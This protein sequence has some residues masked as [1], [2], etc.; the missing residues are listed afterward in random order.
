M[1]TT[2][3]LRLWKI[4]RNGE[5]G[6]INAHNPSQTQDGR[7]AFP[8]MDRFMRACSQARMEVLI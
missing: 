2:S 1:N 3:Q 7:L 4:G 6:G 5:Q 8:R